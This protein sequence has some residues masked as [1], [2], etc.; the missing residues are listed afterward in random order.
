MLKFDEIVRM[1]QHEL[2]KAL[3]RELNRMGYRTSTKKGFTYAA[4]TVPVM[5][6]AHMDT[7]HKT[8]VK[9]TCYSA[10]GKIVMSPEGIGGDDRAGVYM[11]LQIIKKHRC[12]VLFCE[13][14][15][16]GAIGAR[17]FVKSKINP[18]VNYII[19]LDRR[20]SDDAVFYDCD[21]PDFTKF[22]EGFDFKEALGSFSDISVIAPAMGVAAV[23]ISAG[24]F[25]EHSL[26]EYVDMSVVEK[27]IERVGE[28]I[29][30][31]A[32]KFEYIEA[33][34]YGKGR[35]GH[36]FYEDWYD[37]DGYY[38]QNDV[39]VME[40]MSVPDRAYLKSPRGELVESEGLFFIDKSGTVYEYL[41]DIDVAIV[42]DGYEAFSESGLPLK[43]KDEKAVDIEVVSE[44]F[45][46]E[47]QE[48]HWEW[49][50]KKNGKDVK[51]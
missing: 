45:A 27:N 22:V 19:E 47:L 5:L 31:P 11:I 20:G 3:M 8:P 13:D 16:T 51:S 46:Y 2:K 21:N 24:Y 4:G 10:D 41:Y 33:T 34:F 43:F 38:A 14:E 48:E 17:E 30:A 35:Y 36:G 25:C 12:H 6:V 42:A 18:E 15:E 44:E 9:T 39:G 7:V 26:H 37:F 50:E 29:S 1:Q 40:L 23:N 32:E 49:E 28:M